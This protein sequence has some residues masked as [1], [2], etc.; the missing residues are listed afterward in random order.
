IREIKEILHHHTEEI[1]K[2]KKSL[3]TGEK[4]G[5]EKVDERL[6]KLAL[7]GSKN[8]YM[9]TVENKL[10]KKLRELENAV[11]ELSVNI[12][13]TG[14]DREIEVTEE[15]LNKLRKALAE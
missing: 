8:L 11:R 4:N 7:E 12:S 1:E 2:L 3:N 14:K 15:H 9:Q 13:A 10:E 6:M 5:S